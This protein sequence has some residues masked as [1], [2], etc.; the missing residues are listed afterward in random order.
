MTDLEGVEAGEGPQD[1]SL[2]DERRNNDVN[3]ARTGEEPSKQDISGRHG[4]QFRLTLLA[5]PPDPAPLHQ[6]RI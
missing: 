5:R 6:G 1:L 4:L 2:R 3:R